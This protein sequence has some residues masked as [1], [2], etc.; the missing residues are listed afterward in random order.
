MGQGKNNL[1][2]NY[3]SVPFCILLVISVLSRN[4]TV[5]VAFGLLFFIVFLIFGNKV[6]S[7]QSPIY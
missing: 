3:F 7:A 2:E 1:W 5:F 4:V 6:A